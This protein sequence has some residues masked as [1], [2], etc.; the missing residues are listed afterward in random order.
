MQI[1]LKTA[2]SGGPAEIL[3]ALDYLLLMRKINANVNESQLLGILRWVNH[4]HGFL[5]F[6][7]ASYLQMKGEFAWSIIF[8]SE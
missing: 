6:I 4:L 5:Y 2:L 1:W 8:F 7:I 3:V